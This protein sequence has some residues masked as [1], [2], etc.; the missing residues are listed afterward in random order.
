MTEEA[1]LS[2]PALKSILN[3]LSFGVLIFLQLWDRTTFYTF[4]VWLLQCMIYLL[5]AYLI[6]PENVP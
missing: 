3:F 2:P 1:Q 5:I 6:N 4:F